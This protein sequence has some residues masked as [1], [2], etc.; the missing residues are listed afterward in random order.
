MPQPD[1]FQVLFLGLICIS[2]MPYSLVLHIN[3]EG[4]IID[5]I[6]Q[7]LSQVFPSVT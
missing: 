3:N 4:Y 6:V 1:P 5:E 2:F 7:M